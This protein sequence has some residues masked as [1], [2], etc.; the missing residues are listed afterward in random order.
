ME[1][2]S[3]T[4]AQGTDSLPS[5]NTTVFV[6]NDGNDRYTRVESIARHIVG[7]KYVTRNCRVICGFQ[8]GFFRQCMFRL[9]ICCKIY[10]KD[11]IGAESGG[12]RCR[13]RDTY[14]RNLSCLS[15][16]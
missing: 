6:A 7:A 15:A 4:C 13:E 14:V 11:D 10:H 8:Y 9:Y 3:R 1:K 16:N 2:G 5:Y 12:K